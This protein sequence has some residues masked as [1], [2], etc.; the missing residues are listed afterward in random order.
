MWSVRSW[1]LIKDAVLDHLLANNLLNLSQ[2]GFPQSDLM[3]PTC[4]TFIDAVTHEI[5]A[6][7]GLT[8]LRGA[9]RD[10]IQVFKVSH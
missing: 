1:S 6:N 2:F 5:D 10:M 9:R 3:S 4:S 8:T 7:L